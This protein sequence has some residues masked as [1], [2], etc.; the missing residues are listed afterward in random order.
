MKKRSLVLV[1]VDCLRADHVGF[2]GYP[3][4]VTPFLDSLAKDSAIVSDAIIAGVPTYF[5][6]PAIFASRYPLGLGRGVMGIAPNEVTITTALRDAG[7]RTAAFQAGN[8]Y[9]TPHYGYDQGFDT[10]NDFLNSNDFERIGIIPAPH[11]R[12]SDLNHLLAELAQRTRL[13]EVAYNELLFW[14]CQWRA[15]RQR[16]SID[17]LRPY[18][19]ADVIIDAGSS[20]LRSLGSENFFLWIHLMDPHHPYYPPPEALAS[21]GLPGVTLARAR[22]LNTVWNRRDLPAKRLGPYTPKVL[23][24]YDASVRW[25]DQ[26]ICRLVRTLQDLQRWDETL[27]VLTAD[28]GEEFLE[29]GTRFHSPASSSEELIHVPLLLH[30]ASIP[31]T[32]L[33]QRPFSLIHLAPTLLE[34]LGVSVPPSFQGRSLWEPISSGALDCEPAIVESIGTG[35]N[36]TE[37]NHRTRFRLLTIRDRQYKLVLR[38]EGGKDELYEVKHDPDECSTV[39]ESVSTKERARL[40]RVAANHLRESRQTRDSDLVMRARV[41]EIRQSKA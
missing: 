3:R 25:V 34:G 5:S 23:S 11:K 8:P 32:R 40:L 17:Q 4:P 15:S 33:S 20:W 28:H 30:A 12:L 27:F 26:Q 14:Y 24:L 36:P 13:T 29:H 31:P 16:V 2:N 38:F 7:Y 18:P 6:F 22:F 10:F 39:P 35:D 1:T 19:A 21:L 37:R 9:L 41:R